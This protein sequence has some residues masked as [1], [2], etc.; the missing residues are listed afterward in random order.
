MSSRVP[1]ESETPSGRPFAE[2]NPLDKA[3]DGLWQHYLATVDAEDLADVERWNGSTTG[4]LTFVRQSEDRPDRALT[5]T[6]TGLFA[7]TV[8]AF[9]IESYQSSSPD[10]GAHL[11]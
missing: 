10:S 1:A 3:G 5:L 7:A 2:S 6:Q 11:I 9:V 8:A 4:I